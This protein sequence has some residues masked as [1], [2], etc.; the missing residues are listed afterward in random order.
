M[1][2]LGLLLGV[3]GGILGGCLAYSDA[4]ITWENLTGH[5]QFASLMAS[6]TMQKVTKAVQD[7]QRD[8]WKDP[9]WAQYRRTTGEV[10]YSADG[11]IREDVPTGASRPSATYYSKFGGIPVDENTGTAPKS[12]TKLLEEAAKN[13][14]W[15]MFIVGYYP[16]HFFESPGAILVSVGLDR[17]KRVAAN[18]DGQVFSIETTTGHGLTERRL[19]S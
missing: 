16:A 4:K 6:P 10:S 14:D 1:R 7:Y 8:Y 15:K 18:K 19:L 17:I 9:E 11:K 12:L 5:R 13:E 3:C 2:R